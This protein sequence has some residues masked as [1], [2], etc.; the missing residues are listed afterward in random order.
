MLKNFQSYAD[1][2]DD[3]DDDDD[4]DDGDDDDDDTDG[5]DTDDDDDDDD[6]FEWFKFKTIRLEYI[7]WASCEH[8]ISCSDTSAGLKNVDLI[9]NRSRDYPEQT[10]L[11]PRR[12]RLCWLLLVLMRT[13]HLNLLF[14]P[15]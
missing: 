13:Q 10:C 12:W 8:E 14:E 1:C 4:G 6:G 3:T 2:D 11:R 9:P 15:Q 5:D 7:H